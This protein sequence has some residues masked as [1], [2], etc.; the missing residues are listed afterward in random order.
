MARA[1]SGGADCGKGSRCHQPGSAGVPPAAFRRSNSTAGRQRSQ[2]T[3]NVHRFQIHDLIAMLAILEKQMTDTRNSG[4]DLANRVS[5]ATVIRRDE[6][7]AK[8]TTL[9]VG[10]PADVFVEP[11]SEADL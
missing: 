1:R 11:A 7:L 9:R 2:R 6:P 5:N 8:R 3:R 10:G 4:D